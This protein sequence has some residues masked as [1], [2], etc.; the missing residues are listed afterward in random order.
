MSAQIRLTFGFG[1]QPKVPLYFRWHIQFRP[2]VIGPL[3][4][5]TVSEYICTVSVR[6][7]EHFKCLYDHQCRMDLTN[8]RFC[9]HCRLRKCFEIGMKRE[10]ILSAEEKAQKRLKIEQNRSTV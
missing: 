4:T 9:K 8:R 10:Y 2:N 7:K 6:L 5:V 3:V 1:F